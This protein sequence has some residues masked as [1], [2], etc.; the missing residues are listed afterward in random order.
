MFSGYIQAGIYQTIDGHLGIRGW[1]WL[2]IIGMSY[3]NSSNILDMK[4]YLN[5]LTH[6][7]IFQIS[8]LHAPW[9]LLV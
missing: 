4:Q 6:F 7:F 2:F 3:S 1:R 5:L 8:L 9:L